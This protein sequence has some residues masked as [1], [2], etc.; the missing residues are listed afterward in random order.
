MIA[1]TKNHE[2]GHELRNTQAFYGLKNSNQNRV[3]VEKNMHIEPD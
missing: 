1:A 2:D 3:R